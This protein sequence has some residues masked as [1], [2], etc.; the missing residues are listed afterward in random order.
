MSAPAPAPARAA[1]RTL[2]RAVARRVTS[3]SGNTLWRDAVREHFRAAAG[4]RNPAVAAALVARAEDLAYVINAV[5]DHK[6]GHALCWRTCRAPRLPLRAP[7]T[8]SGSQQGLREHA[9]V[10]QRA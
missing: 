6:V 4:E 1:Y 9:G 3:V 5:N 2:M 8:A 10:L 7:R